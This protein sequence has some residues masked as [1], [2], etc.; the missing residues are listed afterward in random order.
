MGE[1]SIVRPRFN[2]LGKL[3]ISENV[4]EQLTKAAASD[5]KGI[6]RVLKVN[7]FMGEEGVNINTGFEG[8][9][10]C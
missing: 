5:I 2:M 1:K 4:I 8:G 6:N 10:W 9:L 3:T 7:V